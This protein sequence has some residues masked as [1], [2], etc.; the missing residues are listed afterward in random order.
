MEKFV[1]TKKIRESLGDDTARF[2]LG[3]TDKLAESTLDQLRK[4]TD[5]AYT[6]FGFLLTAFTALTVII[7]ANRSIYIQIPCLCLWAGLG[8]SLYV[9]FGKAIWVH[10]F[11]QAGNEPRNMIRE[12]NIE[13]LERKFAGDKEAMDR[14]YLRNAIM[15]SIEDNG[16]VIDSNDEELDNR[17]R[18][19]E[20]AMGIIKATVITAASVTLLMLCVKYIF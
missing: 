9:M 20:R 17:V 16:D 4:S 18:A 10:Q 1:I 2:I 8:A 6:L 3:R 14:E 11:K 13:K 5:R 15:D 19:I 7:L 12:K